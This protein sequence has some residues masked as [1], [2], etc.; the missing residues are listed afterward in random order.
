VRRS[1]ACRGWFA[2][3]FLDCSLKHI[4]F[5]PM[6]FPELAIRRRSEILPNEA[7]SPPLIGS[8]WRTFLRSPRN[9]NPYTGF[10]FHQITIIPGLE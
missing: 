1:C 2:P 10:L 7:A 8:N 4:G 6:S 9:Y 3:W 5:D